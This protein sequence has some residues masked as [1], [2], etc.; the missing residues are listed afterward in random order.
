MRLQSGLKGIPQK[1]AHNLPRYFVESGRYSPG[2]R[3]NSK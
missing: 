1:L 3:V 2:K